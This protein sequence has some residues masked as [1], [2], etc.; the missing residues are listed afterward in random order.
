MSDE[1]SQNTA[2]EAESEFTQSG[3]VTE[4]VTQ[5]NISDKSKGV[6]ILLVLFLGYFGIHRFY[7]GHVVSGICMFVMCVTGLILTTVFIG[8]GILAVVELWAIIDLILICVGS[9]TAKDGRK[10]R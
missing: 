9:L 2:V 5:S 10:L 3:T 6:A 8:F 7:L 1:F 4:V